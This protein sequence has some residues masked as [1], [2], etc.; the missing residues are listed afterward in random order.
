MNSPA[1]AAPSLEFD[2]QAALARLLRDGAL[3]DS[4]VRDRAVAI[5]SLG[6][7]SDDGAA[8]AQLDAEALEFQ[9]RVLLRKRFVSLRR[10]LPT[11]L[12]RLGDRAWPTFAAFARM[13]WHGSA[14]QDAAAF[15]PHLTPGEANVREWRRAEFIVSNRRF[16]ASILGDARAVQVLV[17]TRAGTREWFGRFGF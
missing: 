11:T 2:F 14:A 7:N 16:S 4:F 8:L 10:F 15:C 5:A 12:A 13:H 3:R 1:S 6:V 17:R 9:A